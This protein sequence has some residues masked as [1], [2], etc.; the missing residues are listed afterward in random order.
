MSTGLAI[1]KVR[2]FNGSGLTSPSTV[3]V[4]GGLIASI[5]PYA[6]GGPSVSSAADG[7]A[8]DVEVVDGAGAVLLPGL[9]DA[10][11]HVTSPDDVGALTGAG[12]TTALDMATHSATRLLGLARAVGTIDVLTAGAPASAPGGIHTTLMGFP[13]ESAVAS[14]D[15]AAAFVARRVTEGAAYIKLIVDAPRPQGGPPVLEEATLTAVVGAAHEA[16]LRTVAH[17]T[18]IEAVRRAVTAGVDV[19]TH[20]PLE[21]PLPAELVNALASGGTVIVPTLVMMRAVAGLPQGSPLWR[22]GMDLSHAVASVAALH[23]A[24][25]VV[26]AG[27]DANTAPGTIVN[28]PPGVSM[29][30]ELALL[31]SAGLSPVE[32]LRSATSVAAAT[33]GLDDRG[34]VEA[35]RRADLVLVDGDPTTDITA[36]DRVRHVWCAGVDIRISQSILKDNA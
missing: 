14:A 19:L 35:G 34:L 22:P 20:V 30:D 4:H 29:H 28:V 15:D 2:V 3:T 23:E 27:T 25:V 16:G 33:F 13:A 9:L 24:G 10:H 11:V 17:A 5:S 32:A 1:S 21:A 18:T 7:M 26:V 12:V 36:T 6:P 31:V 8:G